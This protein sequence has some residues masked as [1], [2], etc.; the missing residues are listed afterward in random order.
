MPARGGEGVDHQAAAPGVRQFG[1]RNVIFTPGLPG[2]HAGSAQARPAPSNAQDAQSH[3]PGENEDLHELHSRAPAFG[4]QLPDDVGEE[5]VDWTG[6]RKSTGLK[7]V[8]DAEKHRVQPTGEQQWNPDPHQ[9]RSRGQE[10]AELPQNR[11]CP[12]CGT[13]LPQEGSCPVCIA[14]KKPDVAMVSSVNYRAG[15]EKFIAVADSI[16][17]SEGARSLLAESEQPEVASLKY[18]APIVNEQELRKVRQ[19]KPKR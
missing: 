8:R 18:A 13:D 5:D 7:L 19:G 3:Q 10:D 11:K 9:Q 15:G 16:T 6:I 17:T 4:L 14:E 1:G 12:T 2:G